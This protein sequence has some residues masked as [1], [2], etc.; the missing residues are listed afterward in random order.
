MQPK[1]DLSK[2]MK[3]CREL[4][5]VDSLDPWWGAGVDHHIACVSWLSGCPVHELDP[6]PLAGAFEVS[7]E[8]H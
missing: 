4:R 1:S 8:L 7:E 5:L 6:L 2:A 3:P